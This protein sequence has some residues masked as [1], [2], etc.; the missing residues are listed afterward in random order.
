[1]K[2]YKLTLIIGMALLFTILSVPLRSQTFTNSTS[3]NIPS[4][5]TTCV[6]VNVSGIGNI[7]DSYGLEEVCIDLAIDVTYDVYISLQAPDGTTYYLYYNDGFVSGSDMSVTCFNS[8]AISPIWTAS[9][10]YNGSYQPETNLGGFNNGMDADGTWYICIENATG[11]YDGTLSSASITFSS[12]P[13]TACGAIANDDCFSSPLICDFNGYCGTTSGYYTVPAGQDD[14]INGC[15]YSL[16][17]NSWVEFVPN[18]SSV[19]I[20]VTVSD[21]ADDSGVQFGVWESA[22]CNT[23]THVDCGP[24]NPLIGSHTMNFTGLTVGNSYYLMIDGYAGDVCN[25]SF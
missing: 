10:P 6:P 9:P 19:S 8:S 3:T 16:N 4:G 18:N 25:Y 1:M 23:F 2:A 17:N 20:D 12:S 7:S 24:A 22:D 21:C 5:N 15:G 11:I 13:S 14:D